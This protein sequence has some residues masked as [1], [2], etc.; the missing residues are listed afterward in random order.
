[1]TQRL[2]LMADYGCT[3]LWHADDDKVGPVDVDTLPLSSNLREALGKWAE[4]YDSTLDQEY[5]P[6]S[7]FGTPEEAATFE[8][9]G[10][11][12]WRELTNE[13]GKEYKIVFFSEAER[14][15]IEEP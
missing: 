1:M 13:L 12:L 9:E 15:L 14:R 5:P 8:A 6:N 11:R 7:G 4:W 3:V 2:K 10:R